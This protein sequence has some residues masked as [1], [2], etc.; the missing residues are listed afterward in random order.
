MIRENQRFFNTLLVI[1]DMIVIAFSFL[2]AWYVRFETNLLGPSHSIW[3]FHHYVMALIFIL[4]LYICLYYSFGLYN[5]KRTE[6][7]DLELKQ[8]LKV[9]VIALLLIATFLYIVNFQ[10]YSRYML[11]VFAVFSSGFSILERFT[12][13]EFLGFVRSKGRNVRYILVVGAGELGEKFASKI[14]KNSYI[15]Y[16]IIGFLDDNLEIGHKIRDSEVIGTIEDLENIIM[17]NTVDR[18]ILTLS[19]RHYKV[20]QSIVDQ[21]EKHG[22]KAEIVPDYY[23]YLPTQPCLELIDD[24]PVINIRYVPLDNYF[25]KTLKRFLDIVLAIS[26]II[27]TSPILII[28]AAM[29]K[30]TSPG[31]VIFKQERIGLNKKTFMIYKFRSMRAQDDKQEKYQW[32][33]REDPRKTRVGSFIRKT[34]IDE[35]PQ[36]FNILKGDMSLIGPRPERPYFVIKFRDEIPKYMIKHYVRPGMTGWAQVNGWRGDT[37]ISERI[38]HDIYYVENWS[39]IF[40]VKIFFMTFLKWFDNAY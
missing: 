3:Q 29:V 21:V 16:H 9:N 4:P 35:L 1:T 11:A 7:F 20:I 23:R 10:D 38:K 39:F 17:T 13:M 31:P 33:T 19:A 24:I 36:F 14:T 26:G 2:L 40:D 8:I 30:L 15:G 12:L 28:T 25:N 22:V 32:S 37:C 6:N 18:V 34:N 27:L 5:P